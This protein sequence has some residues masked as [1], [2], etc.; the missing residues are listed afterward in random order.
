M[1]HRVPSCLRSFLL[2]AGVVL[3][4]GCGGDSNVGSVSG[5]VTLDGSPVSDALVSFSPKRNG[6]SPSAGKTDS[7]GQYTL[8]YTRS[9]AGAEI[10]EH[11]VK[12]STYQSANPDAEP[13]RTAVAETI[14][15]KYNY[16]SELT[17]EVK[18]GRNTIDFELKKDGPVVQPD[19]LE[20]LEAQREFQRQRGC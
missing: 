12:I 3:V 6:G 20:K 11:D 13:P 10:G 14:P 7:G 18:P 15:M 2:L 16:K 5:T 4:M 19:A 1:K 9:A 8:Q 17:R